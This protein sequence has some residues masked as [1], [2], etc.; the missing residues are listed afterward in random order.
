MYFRKKNSLVWTIG[1]QF[2]YTSGLE[3]IYCLKGII[4]LYFHQI[5]Y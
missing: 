5:Y 2:K 3:H 1:V 4:G